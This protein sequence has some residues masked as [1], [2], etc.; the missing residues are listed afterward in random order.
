MSFMNSEKKSTTQRGII[1]VIVSC[2]CLL[3]SISLIAPIISG[4]AM[5]SPDYCYVNCVWDDGLEVWA[6][7]DICSSVPTT[8]CCIVPMINKRCAENYYCHWM[9]QSNTAF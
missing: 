3:L 8:D 2:V 5:A 9:Q 4:E 6:C 1:R 7:M